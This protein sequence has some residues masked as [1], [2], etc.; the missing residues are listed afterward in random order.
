MAPNPQKVFC[1]GL[2]RTGT[3]AL[4]H[5]LDK[6]GIQ[7]LHYSLDVYVQQNKL[8][9]QLV[10]R[11]LLSL[12][13]YKRW[14]LN[15]EI[16]AKQVK[17]IQYLFD[18]YQGFADLPFPKFYK[19]LHKKYPNAKFILTHRD[20]IKWLKSMQWLYNDAAVIWKHG[21]LDNEIMQW[22]YGTHV[23]DKKKLIQA[24]RTH[25]SEVSAYFKGNKNFISLDLDRGDLHYKNLCT[26]LEL[27]VIDKPVERINT[28]QTPTDNERKRYWLLKQTDVLNLSQKLLKKLF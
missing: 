27:P 4:S 24:Y 21:W 2:S 15:K 5:A 1:I 16:K 10:F 9:E 20:E 17:N 12:S 23:Y 13:R 28:P 19:E 3:T 14:R 25:L 18:K 11:P 8:D 26:F 7:T 22:T 6:L